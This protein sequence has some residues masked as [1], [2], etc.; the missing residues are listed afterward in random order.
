[1]PVINFAGLASGIDSTALI[2]ATSEA[3]RKS[4]VTPSKEKVASLEDANSA[5]EQLTTNL[6]TLKT[7]LS[8]FTT[9]SGGGVSK[10]ATSSKESVVT[11]TTTNAAI[12]GSYSL[13]VTTL[14][15]NHTLSFATSY[16]STSTP[17]QAGLGA[18]TDVTFQ[19]GS[20]T[21]PENVVVTVPD[22]AFTIASFVTAFNAASSTAEASLVNVGT[23]ASPSYKIVV[24]SN[25]EGT[26]LGFITTTIGGALTNLSPVSES[27][28]T[29]ALFSITGIGSISRSSNTVSDVVTGLTLSLVSAGTST[30]RIAEDATT[31]ISQVQEFVDSYNAIVSFIAE[32]NLITRDDS[33]AEIKNVFG[34][35]AN[36][37]TDDNALTNLRTAIASATASGGSTVR[38]FSD[39]GITTERDGTLK[40]DSTKL[41]TAVAAEPASVSALLQD[42][43]DEV[44][45]TGGTI[46]IYIR[47]NGL[48]DVNVNSNKTQITS[49]NERIAE[50]ERQIE[51][52]AE[53][54]RLRFARLESTIGRMQQQQQSLTQSLAGLG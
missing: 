39:L 16:A 34:P 35:L 45:S 8:R 29:N 23:T 17:V 25:N 9:L 31:T 28:A 22:G 52:T 36:T 1:M 6:T 32:N 26:N 33:A 13:T 42:F 21:S 4:R 14:A 18:S 50:A 37:R 3:T 19:I 24:S 12:N 48:F 43:A 15:S 5:F 51:R 2:E 41:Q 20:G 27:P 47:F 11:A 10:S 7:N 30:V 38:V 46:D 44:A 40:F 53:N 54:M 49:L